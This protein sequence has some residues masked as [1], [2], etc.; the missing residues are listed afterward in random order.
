MLFKPRINVVILY[1]FNGIRVEAVVEVE[2]VNT[3]EHQ[4]VRICC[5]RDILAVKVFVGEYDFGYFLFATI[6]GESIAE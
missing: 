4:T 5:A 1:V 6:C 2:L 3:G